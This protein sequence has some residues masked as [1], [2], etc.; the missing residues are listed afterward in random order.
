MLAQ[1]RK[2][3]IYAIIKKNGAVTTATLVNEFNVS[4]ETI[5]RDLLD[6]EKL[7]QLVRV[8]GGAV[9]KS[10]M[11]PM[12]KL[13]ER[14]TECKQQKM[15]L[16][17]KAMQFINEGDII[18][19]DSGSTAAIF[20]EA[21]KE[22]FNSLTVVTNSTDVFNILSPHD[23]FSVILCGGYYMKN[24]NAFY[25]SLTLDMIKNL[26]VSKLFICP[27]A[28]SIECGIC[29]YQDELCLIQKQFMSIADEIF[30]VADSSKF[31]KHA[32][33]K[34]CDMSDDYTYITDNDLPDELIELYRENNINIH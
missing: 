32:L 10:D 33:L 6:M 4:L 22:N 25:G 23:G 3:R 18:G 16:S 13:K 14:N 8:H 19:L 1:E 31:E 34:L 28:I 15:D 12:L 2:E 7:G 27:S 29:D 17:Q 24:E 5:R 11:M 26:H 20:A 9:A 30:V 21:L